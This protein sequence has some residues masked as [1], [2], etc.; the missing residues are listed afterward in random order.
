MSHED[1]E[2]DECPHCD[3][4]AVFNEYTYTGNM[5][6]SVYEDMMSGMREIALT[7]DVDARRSLN[8]I[9]YATMIEVSNSIAIDEA[10]NEATRH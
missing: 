2:E 8:V 9:L 4:L 3:V 1:N 6:L 5:V 7:M 10:K